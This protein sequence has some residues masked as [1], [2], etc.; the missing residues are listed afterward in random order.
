LTEDGDFY[1]WGAGE[2][3]QMA[4][5]EKDIKMRPIL[6]C[7]PGEKITSMACGGASVIATTES[8]MIYSW[9]LGLTGRLGHGDEIDCA[10]P[11]RISFFENLQKKIVEISGRGGHFLVR[12]D[13]GSL[14]SWGLGSGGRL[15][16]CEESNQYT[17]VLVNYFKGRKIVCIGTG[18]DNSLVVV[19]AE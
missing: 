3:L 16:T 13:D 1:T 2:G 19:E 10:F 9:G 7:I 12:T 11:R 14:Y 8:N 5:G 4:N 17:P 18:I 6:S 15:G